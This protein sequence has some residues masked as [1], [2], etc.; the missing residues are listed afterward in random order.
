M[1]IDKA[2]CEIPK[3]MRQ[4]KDPDPPTEFFC[5]RQALAYPGEMLLDIKVVFWHNRR[6]GKRT[7][8]FEK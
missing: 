7:A 2:T 3:L 5:F 6:L 8:A 4:I 1:E